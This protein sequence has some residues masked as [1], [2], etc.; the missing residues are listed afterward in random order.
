[1][2]E[3]RIQQL[4]ILGQIEFADD[5]REKYKGITRLNKAFWIDDERV[6]NFTEY[7]FDE[8]THTNPIRY[9]TDKEKY[10]NTLKVLVCNFI[11]AYKSYNPYISVNLGSS[12]FLCDIDKY[13]PV[14]IT[15]TIF[16]NLINWL[17]DENYINL[18]ISDANPLIGLSSM[19]EV[20][21][22]VQTLIDDYE[23]KFKDI[24]F[25]DNYS[26]IELT[27]EK[28]ELIDYEPDDETKYRDEILKAYNF[29]LTKSNITLE[30]TPIRKPVCLTSRFIQRVGEYGRI[31]GGEWMNCKSEKR[32]TIKID[33]SDTVEI[34]ISNST[35]RMAAH[36]NGN[37]IPHQVDVYSIDDIDREL[38]KD[39]VVIMQ[40]ITS[41]SEADGLN[42]VTGAILNKLIDEQTAKLAFRDIQQGGDGIAVVSAKKTY[43]TRNQSNKE[44]MT[45]NGIPYTRQELREV[46]GRVYTYLNSFASGWLLV[47]RG[48]ELQY[49]ES[50][51][52][53]KVIEK[54]L[55]LDKVVLTIQDSYIA[56]KEDTKLLDEVISS[57][58]YDLFKFKPK[59]S[60]K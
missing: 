26:F 57:S 40:N 58:Y 16:R 49:R 52:A 33:D 60:Y 51:V 48:K 18:Y 38:V 54:F 28:K 21:E 39:I 12:S 45:N 53:F 47:G 15:R 7:L 27:N 41:S 25:H 43:L 37:E 19:I 11:A 50:Q 36:I 9:T 42:K 13:E 30:D 1:M 17:S 23:L 14:R 22:P 20:L 2:A 5:D 6:N 32:K 10:F 4:P 24:F 56:K 44:V 31:N 8:Y 55:E 3:F 35:I 29:F 59:L 46:V 34:D